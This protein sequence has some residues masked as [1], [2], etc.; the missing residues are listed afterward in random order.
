MGVLPGALLP[1]VVAR[2]VVEEEKVVLVQVRRR[3]GSSSRCGGRRVVV[4][5]GYKAES[6]NIIGL[7]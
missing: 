5:I 2:G 4:A 7:F 3:H 6:R 1:A